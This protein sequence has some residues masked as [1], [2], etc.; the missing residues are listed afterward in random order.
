MEQHATTHELPSEVVD[1]L[2]ELYAR[3][4]EKAVFE[5]AQCDTLFSD[6]DGAKNGF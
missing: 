1:I 2:V 5:P 4:L 3:Q 6:N